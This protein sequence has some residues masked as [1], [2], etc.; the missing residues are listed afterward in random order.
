MLK[1]VPTNGIVMSA[2]PP[3]H[4][5]AF[6]SLLSVSLETAW[7]EGTKAIQQA[8]D[9][10]RAA[11]KNDAAAEFRGRLASMLNDPVAAPLAPPPL[12]PP[13]LPPPFS[14]GPVLTPELKRAPRGSVRPA[15]MQALAAEVGLTTGEVAVIAGINENSARGTLN[16]LSSEGK[17]IRNGGKWY[18]APQTKTGA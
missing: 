15:V 9:A 4:L 7:Q 5:K 16:L 18:L 3:Q 12:P 1:T 2:E 10:G 6:Y 13:P 8:F 17:V 11:G 14:A